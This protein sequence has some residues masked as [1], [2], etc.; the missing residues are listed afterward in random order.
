MVAGA[1]VIRQRPFC[2]GCG[3]HY[4]VHDDHRE[5]CTADLMVRVRLFFQPRSRNPSVTLGP[6]DT[7][8]SIAVEGFIDSPKERNADGT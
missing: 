8:T 4:A 1:A 6:V 5:D 3:L 7:A 2:P